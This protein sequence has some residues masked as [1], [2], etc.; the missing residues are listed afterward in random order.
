MVNIQPTRRARSA[1]LRQKNLRIP[2]IDDL[3]Q[4]QKPH[5]A[6]FET[7]PVLFLISNLLTTENLGVV[8]R[9]RQW[10]K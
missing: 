5:A 3:S 4:H 2:Q 6:N 1:Q 7:L 9:N 10:G 8:K